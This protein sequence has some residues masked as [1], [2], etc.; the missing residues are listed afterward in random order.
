MN[1]LSLG[2]LFVVV[3]HR[4]LTT[5]T[6][7]EGPNPDTNKGKAMPRTKSINSPPYQQ[8]LGILQFSAS[9]YQ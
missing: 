3:L 5:S 9:S 2:G 1:D 8:P 7:T 4:L 6:D